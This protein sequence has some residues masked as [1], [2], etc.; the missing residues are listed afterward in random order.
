MKLLVIQ[1]CREDAD[2]NKKRSPRS[3]KKCQCCEVLKFSTFCR[4]FYSI[5]RVL[6]F[7]G[8]ENY[9]EKKVFKQKLLLGKIFGGFFYFSKISLGIIFIFHSL[10]HAYKFHLH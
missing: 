7:V 2:F 3:D 6:Q 1:Y 5:F 10:Y 9:G 4:I 8:G